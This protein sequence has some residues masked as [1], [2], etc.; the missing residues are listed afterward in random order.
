MD[1]G[2]VI[3]ARILASL[4]AVQRSHA[5]VFVFNRLS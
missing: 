4:K 5:S 3:V 2:A 1:D